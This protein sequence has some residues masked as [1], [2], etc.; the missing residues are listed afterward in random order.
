MTSNV[1]VGFKNLSMIPRMLEMISQMGCCGKRAAALA[2]PGQVLGVLVVDGHAG[3]GRDRGQGQTQGTL[4]LSSNYF[5]P[6]G[7]DNAAVRSR[8]ASA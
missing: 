7:S 2:K 1:R 8:S 5:S 6:A 3:Q 4:N